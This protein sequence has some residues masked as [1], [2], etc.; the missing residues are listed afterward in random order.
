[1]RRELL[2]RREEDQRIRNMV[3]PPRGQYMAS[4]PHEGAA[5]WHRIDAENTRWLGELLNARGWPGRTLAGEEGTGAAWLLSG[6]P[7]VLLVTR[8]QPGA[9]PG[10]GGSQ[11]LIR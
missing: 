7:E 5:E 11:D 9:G 4:L 3:S 6:I 1:L 8:R 10:R 2:A